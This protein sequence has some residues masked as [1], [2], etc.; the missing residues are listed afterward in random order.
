MKHR[1]LQSLLHAALSEVLTPYSSV[2]SPDDD[3][4]ADATEIIVKPRIPSEA[5]KAEAHVQLLALVS[6]PLP[7]WFYFG[8]E[9]PNEWIYLE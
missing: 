2:E 1:E 5:Q 9:R 7:S 6:Q 3:E 4:L 8:S